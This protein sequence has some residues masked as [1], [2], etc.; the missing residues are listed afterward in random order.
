MP[1]FSLPVRVYWEDTD[2]GGVVYH[3]RYVAFLERARSEWM[4]EQGYGQEL[5]RRE[6]GLVFAVRAMQLDFLKPARLDD[7]LQVGVGLQECRRASAVFVQEVRCEGA[8]LLTAR[9]RVAALDATDF[10]PR[11]VPSPLLEELQALQL[12]SV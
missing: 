3:A 6:H 11:A 9:V 7:L 1:V 2:A 10:K 5:L 4:R 8:P 12:T